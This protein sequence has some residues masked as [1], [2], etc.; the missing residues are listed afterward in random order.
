MGW[1]FAGTS[2]QWAKTS[3]FRPPLPQP[4]PIDLSAAPARVLRR[5]PG[6]GPTRSAAIVETRWQRGGQEFELNDVP[7]IGE[8]TRDRALEGLEG[9]RE[10]E[11]LPE[12]EDTNEGH[13]FTPSL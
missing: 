4:G 8:R 6:I 12:L 7:G 9:L 5:L 1:V 3:E 2:L 11:G 10:F 13:A